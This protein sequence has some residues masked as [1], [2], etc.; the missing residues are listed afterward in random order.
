MLASPLRCLENCLYEY[1]AEDAAS[2]SFPN[3][4][5][6]NGYELEGRQQIPLYISE[7]QALTLEVAWSADINWAVSCFRAAFH[8]LPQ[9][10]FLFNYSMRWTR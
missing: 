5:V 3:D 10:A 1:N 8:D 6:R 9:R 7:R 4:A 2:I